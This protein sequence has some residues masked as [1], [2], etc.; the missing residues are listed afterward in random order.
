LGDLLGLLPGPDHAGSILVI[1]ALPDVERLA[2]FPAYPLGSSCFGQ[3][4]ECRAK[5]VIVNEAIG[6]E[7]AVRC[8]LPPA[9]LQLSSL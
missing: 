2:A 1:A 7:A 5:T 3:S 6:S 9:N 8:A 4:A